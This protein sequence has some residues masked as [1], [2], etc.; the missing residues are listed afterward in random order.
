MT[1]RHSADEI[2]QNAGPNPNNNAAGTKRLFS[3]GF[4]NVLLCYVCSC[5]V[6]PAPLAL[7]FAVNYAEHPEER[8]FAHYHYIRTT[9]ALM[10]IG[11]SLGGI[12]I[13]LGAEIATQLTLAGLFLVTLTGVL[14]LLR[15]A[16]GIFSAI[17]RQSP[18]SYRS[19]IL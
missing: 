5:A 12:M 14:A 17:M 2:C 6:L 10:V 13:V 16:K 8:L 11:S 9:I 15:C 1:P 4:S 3:P 18:T 7:L 19:Y